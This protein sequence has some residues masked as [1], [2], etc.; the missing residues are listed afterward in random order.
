MGDV[1]PAPASEPN[2]AHSQVRRSR[3]PLFFP[4]PWIDQIQ[5]EE[6]A[7]DLIC[8]TGKEAGRDATQHSG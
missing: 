8:E 6:P 5:G 7:P 3:F 1:E 4:T 2:R